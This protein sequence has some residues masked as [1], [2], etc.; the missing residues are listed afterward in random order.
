LKP[1]KLDELSEN[2]KYSTIKNNPMI[3]EATISIQ[4]IKLTKFTLK[5]N[6]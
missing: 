4:S 2:Q 3:Y 1:N 6:L 5:K